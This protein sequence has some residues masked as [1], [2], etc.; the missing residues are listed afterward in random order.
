MKV[1]FQLRSCTSVVSPE[2]HE[3]KSL[4]P[5]SHCPCYLI[6]PPIPVIMQGNVC[7]SHAIPKNNLFIRSK[8]LNLDAIELLYSG[9]TFAVFN[10]IEQ[11]FKSPS[12]IAV[13]YLEYCKSLSKEHIH[14]F[15]HQRVSSVLQC[16][17]TM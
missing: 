13:I 15:R 4:Q 16:P 8:F 14:Y 9:Y 1:I 7:F 11:T 3:I 2:Q 12:N 5:L 10:V 17:K 6:T